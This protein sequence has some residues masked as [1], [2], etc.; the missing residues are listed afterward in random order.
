ML[1]CDSTGKIWLLC[2]IPMGIALDSG[3]TRPFI[4]SP[5][6]QKFWPIG[7]LQRLRPRPRPRPLESR[8]RSA[9]R[10]AVEAASAG[11]P[12]VQSP[13]CKQADR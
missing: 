3:F 12:V 5:A 8:G 2:A 11:R 10:I 7:L 13:E 9:R 6:G 4:I 1:D